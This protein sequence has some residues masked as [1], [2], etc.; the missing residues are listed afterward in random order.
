[1][2]TQISEGLAAIAAD[3]SGLFAAVLT[4]LVEENLRERTIEA[5]VGKWSG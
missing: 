2:A 3:L 5:F 4:P 1:M